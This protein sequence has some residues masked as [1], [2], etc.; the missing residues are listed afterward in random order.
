MG[1][2]R[3]G[4]STAVASVAMSGNRERYRLPPAH[5]RRGGQA[6]VFEAE[7]KLTGEVVAFKRRRTNL[8]DAV[9][10][11]RR[12]IDVQ[13]AL[14]HPNIMPVLDADSA[15]EPNWFVMPLADGS[16]EDVADA[17]TEIELQDLLKQ[18]AAGLAAA[19]TR[20][21]VHRDVT[22]GNLLFNDQP[23]GTRLWRVADWGLVR[24]PRGETTSPHTQHQLGTEGYIAPEAWSD[25]HGVGAAAD[26]Y[27]LACVAARV[28]TGVTP[29][30]A[31][32]QL[33]RAGPWRSLLRRASARDPSRRI[34][35]MDEFV[36][37]M[38]KEVATPPPTPTQAR[39]ALV[40]QAKR[41]DTNAINSLVDLGLSDQDDVELHLDVLPLLDERAT[42]W[43][44]RRRPEDLKRILEVMSNH[45]DRNW[46]RRDFNELNRPLGF[47]L[48]ATKAAVAAA[49]VD[50][51][52]DL[53]SVLLD[54]NGTW[55]RF[56]QYDPLKSWLETLDPHF[57]H[58][59]AAA[60]RSSP[61]GREWL[62]ER[63]RPNLN[64]S[65]VLY[66]ALHIAQ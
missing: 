32:P 10:R 20:G 40:T 58:A 38:E 42:A 41:G 49:N 43:L 5:M 14:S 34:P 55:D 15:D 65:T 59:V 13:S 22:P 66:A 61:R 23:D 27:S 28:L 7:D 30:P 54:C 1:G 50:L 29:S 62:I 24:R 35:N 18:A 47:M 16:L 64:Y 6:D 2:S 26:V 45:M 46:G 3:N 51:V 17:T 11:M 4:D 33:P 39:E 31:A 56:A 63:V 48:R 60:L 9:R 53:A 44:A 57:H 8:G 21:H 12:E 36:A 37:A 52:E 25:P 19:H